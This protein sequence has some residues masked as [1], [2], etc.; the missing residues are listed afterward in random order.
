MGAVDNTA[1]DSPLPAVEDTFTLEPSPL[2]PE[3]PGQSSGGVNIGGFAPTFALP[4]DP[5][6][7]PADAVEDAS[8]ETIDDSFAPLLPAAAAETTDDVSSVFATLTAWPVENVGG[9]FADGIDG[10]LAETVVDSFVLEL[11]PLL[12][13]KGAAYPEDASAASELLSGLA[14]K[15]AESTLADAVEV[16]LADAVEVTLAGDADDSFVLELS[17]LLPAEGAET[18]DDASPAIGLLSGLAV[19][20]VESSFADAVEVTLVDA[21]EVTLAGIAD[22]PF[23]LELSPLL[24]LAWS[25]FLSVMASE[26]SAALAPGG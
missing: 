23:V 1:D 18:P 17:P 4:V 19:R 13:A 7:T 20:G 26:A 9:T 21:V 3:R 5:V 11:S 8:A 12:P 6:D 25:P 10:T 22:D 15:G 14:A 2:L 16:T 24:P